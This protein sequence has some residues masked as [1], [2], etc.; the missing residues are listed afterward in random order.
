MR[1]Q[2]VL[3]IHEPSDTP[4]TVRHI[5]ESPDYRPLLKE[6]LNSGE[7]HIILDCAPDK[8]LEIFCQGGDVKMLEEYQVS[9]IWQF[10]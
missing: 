8:I 4:I 6:I 9:I 2:D 7:T 3:Q 10:I 1:L 5:G